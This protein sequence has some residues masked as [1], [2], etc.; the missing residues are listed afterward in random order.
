MDAVRLQVL[1]DSVRFSCGSCSACCD[2]PWR[3][4]IDADK[5]RM[6]DQ[7]DFS[8]YPQLAGKRFSYESPQGRDGY[9]ELA[10]G[11][12]T[13]CL[14]LDTD[15]L[16]II[17][18]E[19]GPE[20]KPRMCRQF[21]FLPARTS[22]DDRVSVNFGC[23]SV[24]ADSGQPLSEQSA[25]IADVVPL[26][27]RPAT[28]N[29]PVPL[30]LRCKLTPDEADAISDRAISIF[31]ER[32]ATDVWTAF[33]KLLSL[34]VAV[35]RCKLRDAS[36]GG[37]SDEFLELLRSD[38]PLPNA[39]DPSGVVAYRDPSDAP[40]PVRMLFAATLQPDTLPADATADMGFIKRLAM[41][42][43]MLTLA[44]LSGG[45]ASRLLGRNIS[46]TQVLEHE[47]DEELD[48]DATTLLLRYYRA[49]FWQRLVIGTRL[50]IIGGVH[51]HILDLNAILFLARAEAAAH[52]ARQLNHELIRQALTHVEFHLA[53]QPRLSD[54]TLK[55][56]LRSRLCD[57]ELAT[58]S[59]RLMA[60]RHPKAPAETGTQSTAPADRT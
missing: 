57:A 59:L 60:L 26:T 4:M 50:P 58:Q 6:L 41:V 11:E 36:L 32:R 23:P 18:K 42:P 13:R 27:K 5:A 8:A 33:A 24:Q 3:T 20:A 10:K 44:T 47:V 1:D 7:H 55:G 28:A 14:F 15:G 39:A 34:L 12:G 29:A 21:P 30:D 40:M 43:K 48:S 38:A 17:H 25:D 31:I 37:R 9:F 46:I 2:Q 54:H 51:Q 35:R 22:V 19:M 52:G 49:R 56:W 16:C 53:N 45:Y